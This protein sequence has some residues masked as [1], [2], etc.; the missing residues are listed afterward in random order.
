MAKPIPPG[1]KPFTKET[2]RLAGQKAWAMRRERDAEAARL[3]KEAKAS[4][5]P[6]WGNEQAVK[7]RAMAERLEK[8][9]ALELKRGKPDLARVNDMTSAIG[10]LVDVSDR[11]IRAGQRQGGNGSPTIP[12][13]V[14][15][16][17]T[18]H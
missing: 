12:P 8:L 7:L 15:G 14:L 1:L 6:T 10:K 3:A 4:L 16:A 17:E 5:M 18:G 2:A 13:V 11:M 9:C